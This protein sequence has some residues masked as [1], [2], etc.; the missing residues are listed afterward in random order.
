MAHPKDL[1][2]L[3]TADQM[4]EESPVA[5]NVVKSFVPGLGQ[6]LAA[7]DYATDIGNGNTTGAVGNALNFM[8]G[9]GATRAA[10]AEGLAHVVPAYNA[11][12]TLASDGLQAAARTVAP[13]GLRRAAS[14]NGQIIGND[15]RLWD[16]ATLG[17]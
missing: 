1:A 6:A 8:P 9:Y 2:R 4:R 11:V 12:K 16:A 7:K 3:R 14:V 17:N 10:A 13:L 15:A 5:Y